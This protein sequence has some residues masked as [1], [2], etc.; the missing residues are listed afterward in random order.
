MEL[1][2]GQMRADIA[3]NRDEL[4]ALQALAADNGARLTLLR[5]LDILVWMSSEPP[6]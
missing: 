6:V 1:F 5:I 4:V 3:S 2:C